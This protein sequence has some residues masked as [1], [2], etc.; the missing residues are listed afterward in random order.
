MAAELSSNQKKRGKKAGVQGS[1][2]A[3]GV[4][5]ISS[6]GFAEGWYL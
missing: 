2:G 6:Q 3:A 1:A 5:E 4:V